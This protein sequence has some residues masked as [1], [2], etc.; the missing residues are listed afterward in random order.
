MQ[1]GVRS[2]AF[3]TIYDAKLVIIERL[4][5]PPPL[6]FVKKSGSF[7]IFLQRE[8]RRGTKNASSDVP[9]REKCVLKIQ[10]SVWRVFSYLLA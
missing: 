6:N 2:R 3:F 9:E 1:T 5:I 4:A 8:R 7:A 10:N